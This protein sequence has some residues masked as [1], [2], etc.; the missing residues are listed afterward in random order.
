MVL[1]KS[2]SRGLY[3]EI[4]NI[5]ITGLGQDS[6]QNLFISIAKYDTAGVVA[7]GRELLLQRRP[8]H[9][10]CPLSLSAMRQM[11]GNLRLVLAGQRRE[12][13]GLGRHISL[14]IQSN[15]PHSGFFNI[16]IIAVQINTVFKTMQGCV[17]LLALGE[18]A[19]LK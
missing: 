15:T 8:G 12:K 18:I 17:R 16:L 14:R 5:T 4:Y 11:N 6:G 3:F 2:T 9:Q 13:S 7:N 19:V 1:H 10:P